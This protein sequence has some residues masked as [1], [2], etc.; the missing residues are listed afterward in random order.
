MGRRVRTGEIERH[1]ARQVFADL[2][3]WIGRGVERIDLGPPDVAAAA[4]LL[5]R[6]DLTLRTPD[7][8]NLALCQRASAA[9]A[10]FD[11]RMAVAARAIGLDVVPA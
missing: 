5:R 10:T 1:R 9:L 7:A 6:L 2:D 3:A 8:L 4:G 11:A